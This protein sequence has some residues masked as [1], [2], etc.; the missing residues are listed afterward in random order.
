MRIIRFSSILVV[1]VAI[2]VVS[3]ASA[4]PSL[5]LGSSASYQ[6]NASLTRFDSC[7]S[8]NVTIAAVVCGSTVPFQTS[9]FVSINDDG[10]CLTSADAACQFSPSNVT[11]SVSG[12]VIWRNFGNLTHT[13]TSD[14]GVFN[15]QLFGRSNFTSF[16]TQFSFPSPGRFSYRCTYHPWMKGE[17]IVVQPT[18]LP[19]TVQSFSLTGPVGW[20]TVGLDDNAQLDVTHKITA[21]NASAAPPERLYNESGITGETVQLSTRKDTSSAL[22]PFSLL[23]SLPFPSQGSFQFP[24]FGYPYYYSTPES[25]TVWWVNGP[26]SVGSTVEVLTIQAAVRGSESVT[27][28]SGSHDAWTV[29]YQNSEAFNQTKPSAQSNY[30][31]CYYPVRYQ[32]PGPGPI[33]FNQNPVCYTS[34]SSNVLSLKLA[35]GEQ[36]DLLF[37]LDGL[38][39]TYTQTTTVYPAGSFV[40]GQFYGQGIQVSSPVNVVRTSRSTSSVGLKLTSTSLDL[41][42]RTVPPATTPA[43]SSSGSPVSSPVRSMLPLL[44]YGTVSVAAAGLVGAGVWVAVR[45][46]KK[47]QPVPSFQ[48]APQTG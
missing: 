36:S 3:P 27:V 45:A 5:S 39:D 18:L 47:G 17:V 35:Y 11:V 46:R 24:G 26:L 28:G 33:W 29:S 48:Q 8:T 42:S 38:V 44:M 40:Y 32:Y 21:Y 15:L 20:S 12:T 19:P 34:G 22:N 41:A 43:T 16:S 2:L 6:L 9:A 30:Y 7:T 14:T 31:Y 25:Y 10:R 13:V 23:N 37:S 1:L 4:A